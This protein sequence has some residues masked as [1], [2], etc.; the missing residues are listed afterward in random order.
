MK[1]TNC[2]IGEMGT[3]KGLKAGKMECNNCGYRIDAPKVTAPKA[4]G[5][6]E[7]ET[8]E[9]ATESNKETK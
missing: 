9:V 7:P 4:K 6:T 8:A 3:Y 2:N 1:C 5:K